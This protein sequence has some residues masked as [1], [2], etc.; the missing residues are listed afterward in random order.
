MLAL[1]III[2]ALLIV[3]N[4][5]LAMSELAVVSARPARLKARRDQGVAGAA[6]ALALARDPGRFLSTVQIGI[7]LVGVLSGAFSGATLG[8]RLTDWLLARGVPDNVADAVGVGLVVAIITYFSLIA[9][10]L[11]PKRIALA[12]PEKIAIRAAPAMTLLSRVALPLVWLLDT[13]GRLALRLLGQR[14]QSDR[15]VSDEEIRMLI[16]EAEHTGTIEADERRMITGVMRLADRKAHAVMTPR[17][18]VDWI[19]LTADTEALSGLLRETRHS[20]LPA[21]EGSADNLVGVIKLRDLLA[22]RLPQELA[23]R[24][25]TLDL[26]A[27]VLSAPIVHDVADAL[28]VLGTLR[29]AEVPMALVHDEYGHFEGVVTP[30]D[31]LETIAG[32]FRSDVEEGEHEII[33]REDGSWLLPG[34]MPADEMADHLGFVLPAEHSYATLAGF[35]LTHFRRIPEAGERIEASGW[36]FEVMDMDGRR[37]DQVLAMK[38]PAATMRQG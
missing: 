13:S 21:G 16:A 38:T 3:F 15:N 20:I 1:E 12:N 24:N 11:V 22:E 37:I 35:L 29:E 18:E 9:G 2:V 31:I 17:G 30:S 36:T 10:E 27:H 34:A 32:V 5:L 28:A 14:P 19:D 4:G 6:K 8:L 25:G 23:D 26:R 33:E 7:T